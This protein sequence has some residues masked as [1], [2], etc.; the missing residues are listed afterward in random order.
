[1]IGWH[2]GKKSRKKSHMITKTGRSREDVGIHCMLVL[3]ASVPSAPRTLIYSAENKPSSMEKLVLS[4]SLFVPRTQRVPPSHLLSS[5]CW[6]SMEGRWQGLTGEALSCGVL[7]DR[8]QHD[9][10]LEMFSSPW[11]L[12]GYT[13]RWVSLS[14]L[15][16][17]DLCQAS[18]WCWVS[19]FG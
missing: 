17:T 19:G 13:T 4:F 8:L 18:A 15:P 14:S 7:S 5:W 1:M 6:L 11:L 3:V 2:H 9:P 10:H 16:S 12:I